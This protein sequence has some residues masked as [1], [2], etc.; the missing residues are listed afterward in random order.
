MDVTIVTTKHVKICV[1]IQIMISYTPLKGVFIMQYYDSEGNLRTFNTDGNHFKTGSTSY[2]FKIGDLALKEYRKSIGDYYC[3]DASV[4][5]VLKKID[6]PNFLKL[7]EYFFDTS[8]VDDTLMKEEIIEELKGMPISAYSYDFILEEEIDI[9]N[10]SKDY[11]LTNLEGL[12]GLFDLFDDERL[13][14][15]DIKPANTIVN[16]EGIVLI[17]PDYF[18]FFNENDKNFAWEDIKRHNR[19]L[20]LRLMRRLLRGKRVFAGQSVKK[21]LSDD[22]LDKPK[23]VDEVSKRLAYVKTPADIVIR[24]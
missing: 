1:F 14:L 22:L 13:V 10:M 12:E 11:F 8:I 17:D 6:H 7:Q 4:F 9:L 24:K 21:F 3:L 15:A 19:L 18:M 2:V 23:M 5:N 16:S 20:L